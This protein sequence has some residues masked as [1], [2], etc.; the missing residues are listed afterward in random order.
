MTIAIGDYW[1]GLACT[2]SMVDDIDL[3]ELERMAD[4]YFR[5]VLD[6]GMETRMHVHNK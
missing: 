2:T 6:P 1:A 3:E 5:I 4:S